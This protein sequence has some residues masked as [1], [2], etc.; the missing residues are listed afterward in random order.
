MVHRPPDRPAAPGSEQSRTTLQRMKTLAWL[1]DSSI[2]LP[3]GF[4]IGVDALLGL[5]P[6]LGD[7]VGVLFS[8]YIVARAA[9]L[10]V[11][12][13]VLLR[14]VMNVA[15]EGV[16]GLVPLLGDVFDAAWK[17]NQRN[18]DLL[19]RHLEQPAKTHRASRWF[20]ALCGLAL[21]VLASLLVI[22][23][24]VLIKWTWRAVS[25]AG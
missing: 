16:L 13:S 25:G 24:L 8:S 6:L 18:V 10:G 11:P 1:L 22:G 15:I 21:I 3:G 17:A 5:I 20:V 19:A 4:R 14:M 9:R 7:M 2:R 23:S 12:R